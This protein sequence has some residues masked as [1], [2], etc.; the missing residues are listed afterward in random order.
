V[1]ILREAVMADEFAP[2]V[3]ESLITYTNVIYALHA[4]AVVIGV[5]TTTT[6]VGN[7]VFGLPSIVAV[8][9]N[10]VKRSQ[11]RGTFL[12]SHFIWQITTF[13]TAL[14]LA[15]VIGAVSFALAF[16]L[17]GFVTW[18]VGMLLLGVWVIY[19]VA[20]GWFALRDRRPMY[21]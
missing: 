4:L 5:L 17:I 3:D 7:F 21:V 9:M 16:I 1:R 14:L 20:R 12:E 10:Y 15:I 13:W 19:R 11:V 6:I 18:P 8:I 2:R